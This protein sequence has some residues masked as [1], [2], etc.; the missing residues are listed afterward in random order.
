MKKYHITIETEVTVELDETKFTPDFMRDFS[1]SMYETDDLVGHA[2]RLAEWRANGVIESDADFQEGYGKL[3]DMGIKTR[4]EC[5]DI[6][7][8]EEVKP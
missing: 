6:M 7:D 1:E 3:T 2:K 4:V 8:V 5:S